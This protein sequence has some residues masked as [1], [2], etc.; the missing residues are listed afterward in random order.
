MRSLPLLLLLGACPVGADL[1]DAGDAVDAGVTGPGFADTYA[2]FTGHGCD[3]CH[4]P[5]GPPQGDLDLSTEDVAFAQLVGVVA[6]GPFC[7]QSPHTRVVAGDADASLLY[8]KLAL[9]QDCGLGMPMHEG[10]GPPGGAQTFTADEL[11]VVHAWIVG[12]AAR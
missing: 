2:L 1:V 5:G 9:T 4:S 10:P 12:G 3:G 6:S 11:L 7:G 8:Q